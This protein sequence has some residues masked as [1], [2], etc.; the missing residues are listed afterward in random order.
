[1]EATT[2]AAENKMKVLVA[3]DESDESFYALR[4]ALDQLFSR[5]YPEETQ[6]EQEHNSIT[7]VNV[8][9]IFQ[10]FIYPAGP[11]VYATTSMVDS[12][13]K[14]QEENAANILSRAMHLC[15]QKKVKAETLV[16][17]GDPKDKICQAAEDLHV[18]L[19][20]VGSRGFGMIK[21]ALLGSV[22]NYCAHHAYCPVLVV[23]PPAKQPHD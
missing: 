10:P 7:L 13:K 8:Q 1:M 18:D 4:W 15:K 17:Q 3:I 14:A 16:L 6:Q 22:S 19:V 20:V 12:V 23:K 2:V 21:R 9:P 11:V 5:Y